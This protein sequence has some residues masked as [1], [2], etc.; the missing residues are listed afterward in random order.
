MQ[1]K[2][3][4]NNNLFNSIIKVIALIIKDVHKN[5]NKAA[6]KLNKSQIHRKIYC[7]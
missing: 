4:L 6:V 5:P 2:I 3:K 1:P 7:T